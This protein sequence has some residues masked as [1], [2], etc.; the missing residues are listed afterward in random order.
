[1]GRTTSRDG[2]SWMAGIAAVLAIG[3]L[4]SWRFWEGL[5]GDEE[6]LSITVRNVGLVIGGVV[7]ILLAVWRSN[8]AQRQANTAQQTLLNERYQRGAEMLGSAV[9]LLAF[10]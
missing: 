3:V 1:M 2:F 6:S 5:A 10:Y 9:I 4:L 8:V 7:A